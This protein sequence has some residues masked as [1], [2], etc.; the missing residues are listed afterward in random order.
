MAGLVVTI[1]T[2]DS[3]TSRMFVDYYTKIHTAGKR[4]LT[5]G[6][7]FYN[8]LDMT[9]SQVKGALSVAGASNDLLVLYR[10]PDQFDPSRTPQELLELSNLVFF[11]D[12][13]RSGGLVKVLKAHPEDLGDMIATRFGANIERMSS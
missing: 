2:T 3:L 8:S 1:L 7:S 10:V 4:P 13:K 5:V 12:P 11:S 6:P 9:V